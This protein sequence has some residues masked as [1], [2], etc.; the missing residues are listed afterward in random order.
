[1]RNGEFWFEA[2]TKRIRIRSNRFFSAF[3]A[4][5]KQRPGCRRAGAGA[6]ER[7]DR[8]FQNSTRDRRCAA[9]PLHFCVNQNMAQET[10]QKPANEGVIQRLVADMVC[11]ILY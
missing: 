7:R 2:D 3:P 5:S 8:S 4:D 9:I 10:V 11:D 1:M 6:Q